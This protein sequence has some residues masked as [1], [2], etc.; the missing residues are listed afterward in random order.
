[1]FINNFML[2]NFYKIL[3]GVEAYCPLENDFVSEFVLEIRNGL[4]E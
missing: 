4:L 2:G 1:M 3:E